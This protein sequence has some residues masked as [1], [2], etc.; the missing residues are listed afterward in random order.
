MGVL[1]RLIKDLPL[2]FLP[3][4]ITFCILYG[5]MFWLLDEYTLTIGLC[6][7]LTVSNLWIYGKTKKYGETAVAYMLGLIAVFSIKW[8]IENAAI[9]SICYL[10]FVSIAFMI[11]RAFLISEIQPYL[12][13]AASFI[14]FN[15]SEIIYEELNKMVNKSQHSPYLR[16]VE[17][18]I[19]IESFAHVGMEMS[20]FGKS[21]TLVQTIKIIFKLDLKR[22]CDMFSVLFKLQESNSNFQISDSLNLYVNANVEIPPSDVAEIII[23]CS[24]VITQGI[25]RYDTFL[26]EIDRWSKEGMGKEEIIEYIKKIAKHYRN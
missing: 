6:F 11:Y 10:S 17:R 12:K 13:S 14:D 9:F 20:E 18:A 16:P 22:A 15:H 21:L 19:V 5:L 24:S 7:A 8:N 26:R 1:N 3:S 4:I 2:V 25:I 23:N